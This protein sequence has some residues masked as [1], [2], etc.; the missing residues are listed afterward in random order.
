M[1]ENSLN[2]NINFQPKVQSYAYSNPN[3]NINLKKEPNFLFILTF[4]ILGFLLLFFALLIILNYFRI[5]SLSNI[6]PVAEKLPIALSP[7]PTPA[8]NYNTESKSFTIDAVF[9]GYNNYEIKVKYYNQIITLQFNPGESVF[10]TQ[11][12]SKVQIP[13]FFSDLEQEKNI[14]K[15]INV[16]YV[17]NDKENNIIQQLI[18]YNN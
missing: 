6:A 13:R 15:K 2:Q 11:V 9:Y 17:K 1:P 4:E 12:D 3:S 7:T 14:G 16:Q 10:Y 8:P 5:I 18:L